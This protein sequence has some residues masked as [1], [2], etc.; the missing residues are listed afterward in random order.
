MKIEIEISEQEIQDAVA[1]KVRVAIADQTNAWAANDHIKEQV[2]QHWKGAVQKLIEEALNDSTALKAK[3]AAEVE[4]K[5]R[6][7]VSAAM[8]V[9]NEGLLPPEV[10]P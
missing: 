4:R 1:R 9:A 3:I 2:K 5:L 6:L 8:K 10:K 7:Q